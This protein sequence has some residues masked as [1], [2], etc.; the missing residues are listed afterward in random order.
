MR[1][2]GRCSERFIVLQ[3]LAICLP[4]QLHLTLASVQML[5]Y[6]GHVFAGPHWG[7]TAYTDYDDPTRH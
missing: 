1:T 4:D 5:F 2:S 3:R 7:S 6:T